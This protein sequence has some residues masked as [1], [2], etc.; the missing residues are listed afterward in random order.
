MN[1]EFNFGP[2]TTKDIK[3]SLYGM[4]VRRSD[5]KWVAYDKESGSLIDVDIFNLNIDSSKV[6]Y[7][8]PKATKSVKP[9]D[10][11]LH[12]GKPMFVEKVRKDGKF[13]VVNPAEGT[14]ITIL[15]LKSPFGFDFT[16]VIVNI[17]DCLPQADST[18]PFGALLPFM[19][20]GD[21]TAL[22]FA[23]MNN[24][25]LKDIDPMILFALGNNNN[26][27]ALL[28]MQMM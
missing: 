24:K 10:V 11:I 21:S 13:E 16:T 2:Y 4:A 9:G 1:N 25:N 20:D 8:L 6:F 26:M 12:N 27:S 3:L 5:N 14:A 7:K 18:N 19:L 28:L 23:L 17:A 22:M 15:P